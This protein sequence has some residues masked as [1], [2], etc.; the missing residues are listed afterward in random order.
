[1]TVHFSRETKRMGTA[2]GVKC[3]AENFEDTFMVVMGDALTDADVLKIIAFHKEKGALA[4]IA[5]RRIY[6]PS[7]CGVVVEVDDVGNV[8]GFQEEPKPEEAIRTL[9]S[10]G[11]YVLE[12]KVLEC[13]TES[14]FSDFAMDVFPRLLEDKERFVGY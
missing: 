8:L 6:D 11:I 7:Q 1:M 4:T 13:I 9:A 14:A 12:P 2:G 3:L 10:T 5:L